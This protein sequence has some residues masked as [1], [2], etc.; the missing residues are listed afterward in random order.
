MAI[1]AT[2][3]TEEALHAQYNLDPICHTFAYKKVANHAKP[4]A[5]MMPQHA[6]I[7]QR[8]PEDPLLTL[9]PLTSCPPDFSSGQCLTHNCMADLGILNNTFLLPD[10]WKLATHVLRINKLALAWDKSEKGHFCDKYFNPMV[11]PTI[12]HTPW[13]HR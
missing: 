8:F 10:E 3:F 4:V 13:V 5:T 7:I 1:T 9:T 6:H 11:I 2:Q 12:E